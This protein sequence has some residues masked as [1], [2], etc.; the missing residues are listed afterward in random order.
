MAGAIMLFELE[1]HDPLALAGA[2][3]LLSIVEGGSDQGASI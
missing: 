2:A 1:P 3:A